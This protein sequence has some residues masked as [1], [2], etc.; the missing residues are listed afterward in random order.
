[1]PDT[2]IPECNT[3]SLLIVLCCLQSNL[4]TTQDG[5]SASSSAEQNTCSTHRAAELEPFI[6]EQCSD[7]MQ[8]IA[9]QLDTHLQR[10]GQPE[11]DLDG[12]K[13]VEQALLIGKPIPVC[14]Q[15]WTLPL[16]RP[17]VCVTTSWFQL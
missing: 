10:L 7:A 15:Q 17:T 13:L 16:T 5:Y 4:N 11:M 1:M 6:Q 3:V 9:L 14:A 12:A 8:S 2:P